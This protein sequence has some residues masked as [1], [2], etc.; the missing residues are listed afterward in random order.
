MAPDGKQRLAIVTGATG[1]IGRSIVDQPFARGLSVVAVGRAES[2]LSTLGAKQAER[3]Q[4]V[5]WDMGA[6]LVHTAGVADV[7]LS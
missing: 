4:P 3:V 1:G 6:H 7:A 5:I 2:T